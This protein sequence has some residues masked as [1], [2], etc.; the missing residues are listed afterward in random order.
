MAKIEID[1]AISVSAGR[2]H[3]MPP[4]PSALTIAACA[5]PAT[6]VSD[7]V[8]I[9]ATTVPVSEMKSRVYLK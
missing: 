5:D 4:S 2:S 6:E 3:S 8:M 1:S 9:S 7:S